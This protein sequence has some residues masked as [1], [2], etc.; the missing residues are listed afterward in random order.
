MTHC[1]TYGD[2]LGDLGHGGDFIKPHAL[3]SGTLKIATYQVLIIYSI[4]C[5]NDAVKS[6]TL[7]YGT[8]GR[9]KKVPTYNVH[10]TYVC[11]L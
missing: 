10:S 3:H 5:T 1:T 7:Y 2:L 4:Q 8:S 11:T 6:R 9:S